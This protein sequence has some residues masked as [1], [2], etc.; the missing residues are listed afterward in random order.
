[1]KPKLLLCLALVLSGGLFGCSSTE[2]H[3]STGVV[4]T[5]SP[6]GKLVLS[7][8]TL[9]GT[10]SFDS[11]SW[12]EL[13]GA[14][15]KV[16]TD[17]TGFAVL[18]HFPRVT[19]PNPTNSDGT[20]PVAGLLLSGNTLFGTAPAGG[21]AGYGT[22]FKVS[23]D[24]KDFAVLHTFTGSD[25]AV[26]RSGLV[27]LDNT[28][29]GIT[30]RGGH[31]EGV[32]F[33]VNT[34][35]TAF[36]TLHVFSKLVA[37]PCTTTNPITGNVW[38]DPYNYTN[39]DG[40]FSESGLIL[41]GNALYGTA[42]AGG[43]DEA[44][45]IFK[46]NTDGSGFVVLHGFTKD[47][48]GHSKKNSV[49]ANSDD[50][51]PRGVLMVNGNTLYGMAFQ[52]DSVLGAAVKINTGGLSFTVPQNYHGIS[53][54]EATPEDLFWLG[55][56]LYGM[57]PQGGLV[58]FGI[59]GTDFSP[60]AG[61]DVNWISGMMMSGKIFYGT[62]SVGGNGHGGTVFRIN[63]DGTGF[64]VLHNFIEKAAPPGMTD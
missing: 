44:G 56:T 26:P 38:V 4:E 23:T 54:H 52:G 15:F 8:Q 33:K 34:D 1:M 60:L 53:R 18:H 7:G 16:N 5:C 10:T 59:R 32:I 27:L 14:V 37:R 58:K 39:S 12:G 28:L 50:E 40:A 57:T 11:D 45:T 9:Y 36:A 41:S 49:D 55:N 61:F 42:H 35:G 64:K 51:W 30:Q 62:T 20:G 29:Y 19:Y 25:G 17:G 3:D 46:I 63:A 21:A 6:G 24:G 13:G 22:V 47:R 2:H 43:P 48:A 31:N